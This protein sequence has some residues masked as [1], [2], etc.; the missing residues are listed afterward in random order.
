ML[1]SEGEF[2]IVIRSQIRPTCTSKDLEEH[3][4]RLLLKEPL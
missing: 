4:I 1:G 2:V 3:V